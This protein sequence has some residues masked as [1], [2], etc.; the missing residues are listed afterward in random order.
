MIVRET[1]KRREASALLPPA[2][3]KSITRLRKSIEYLIRYKSYQ[4]EKKCQLIFIIYYIPIL[5]DRVP[6]TKNAFNRNSLP[7]QRQMRLAEYACGIL[8]DLSPL[9]FTMS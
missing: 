8:H 5:N 2:S 4:I 9:T 6:L 3:T 1:E 7:N